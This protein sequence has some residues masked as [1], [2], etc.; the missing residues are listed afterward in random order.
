MVL[1]AAL[2][3]M[4]NTV[5]SNPDRCVSKGG[6]IQSSG[7]GGN[8]S[9]A[10]ADQRP[11][12]LEMPARYL[13]ATDSRTRHRKIRL[14]RSR[15]YELYPDYLR[16][17]VAISNTAGLRSFWRRSRT[18]WQQGID[19]LLRKLSSARPPAPYRFAA[20]EVHRRRGFKSTRLAS[21]LVT[22]TCGLVSPRA[23]ALSIVSIQVATFPPSLMNQKT[24]KNPLSCSKSTLI[25][26]VR[27]CSHAFVRL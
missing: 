20:S 13:G 14:G 18:D 23:L 4:A 16:P 26:A 2:R 22:N 3:A 27:L 6:H 17:P 24:T 7:P 10:E 5:R 25:D 1:N 9:V 19:L 15:F 8:W 12:G 11:A 21:R